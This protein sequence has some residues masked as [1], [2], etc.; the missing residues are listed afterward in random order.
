M[1]TALRL[2]GVALIALFAGFSVPVHPPN[3]RPDITGAY[4]WVMLDHDQYEGLFHQW[5]GDGL[6]VAGTLVLTPS[7][8]GYDARM[9]SAGKA[10]PPPFLVTTVD[11]RTIVYVD[12]EMGELRFDVPSVPGVAA[13]WTLRSE[14][15]GELHG[16]L[17]VSR[18]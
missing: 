8:T 1:L 14:A 11:D 13:E 15:W 5:R 7:P 12:T 3:V 6:D 4:E 17:E 9:T 10:T 2:A 18:R 16:R